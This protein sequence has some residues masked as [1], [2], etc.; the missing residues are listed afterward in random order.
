[1]DDRII[2]LTRELGKELQQ[3]DRYIAYTLAKQVND[4]DAELQS[5]ITHF[6]ELRAEMRTVMS[7]ENPDFDRINTIDKETQALYQKIMN[8]PHMIV[9]NATQ[10]ALEELVS[11]MNQII[12]MCANGQ[13]PETCEIKRGCSGDCTAC[14][15][16]N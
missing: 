2:Q 8:N 5:E 4:E 14:G 6:D 11:N 3:D 9:F 15:G 7:S 16:C 10:K 13:N 12:T 1:M